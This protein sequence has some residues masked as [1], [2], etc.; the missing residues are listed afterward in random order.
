M[1]VRFPLLIPVSLALLSAC[2]DSRAEAAAHSASDD[3]H[4]AHAAQA[5]RAEPA[6]PPAAS[7]RISLFDLQGEWT[8]Q[9]G[10]RGPLGDIPRRQFTVV[11]MLY[12]HCTV[13]CPRILVDLK[14]IEAALPA[15]LL[16]DVRFVIASID[17]AR[18]TPARLRQWAQDVQLD[19]ARFTLLTAPDPTVRELATALRVRYEPEPNGEFGHTNRIVVVNADGAVLHWQTGLGE[20]SRYTVAAITGREVE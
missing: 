14:R 4:A 6:A 13:S 10:R 18:D 5:G 20:G 19:P 11:T 1:H 9:S 15:E 17:P 3:P 8:D 12:T 7:G 16:N 2:G